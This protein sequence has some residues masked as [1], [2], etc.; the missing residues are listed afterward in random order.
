VNIIFTAIFVFIAIMIFLRINKLEEDIIDID[1]ELKIYYEKLLNK[2]IDIKCHINNL[3]QD[4]SDQLIDVKYYL[5]NLIEKHSSEYLQETKDYYASLYLLIE[6][7]EIRIQ[8]TESN[9]SVL[10]QKERLELEKVKETK[11]KDSFKSL[12][13][14]FSPNGKLEEDN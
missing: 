1:R 13:A 10:F 11:S 2:F 8:E 7:L 3:K 5:S 4:Y 6:K 9:L 14:A 12:K